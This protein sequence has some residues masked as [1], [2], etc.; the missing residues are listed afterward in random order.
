M[1]ECRA[2]LDRGD[3]L[4]VTWATAHQAQAD[5]VPWEHYHLGALDTQTQTY[6]LTPLGQHWKELQ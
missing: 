3:V 1:D 5:G 6:T 4:G 2:M